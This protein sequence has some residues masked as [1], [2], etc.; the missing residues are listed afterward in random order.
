MHMSAS[1]KDTLRDEGYCSTSSPLRIELM[2]SKSNNTP[3]LSSKG[4]T[5]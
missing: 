5:I 3:Q 2:C 1:K 4:N